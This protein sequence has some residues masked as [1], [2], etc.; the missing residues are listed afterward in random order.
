MK[1][2]IKKI[3]INRKTGEKIK[4]EILEIKEVDEDE[5]FRPL[6]EIYGRDFYK[7][8]QRGRWWLMFGGKYGGKCIYQLLYLSLLVL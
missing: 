1:V 7:E 8:F 5:Y 6:V 2:A 3:K 4:E